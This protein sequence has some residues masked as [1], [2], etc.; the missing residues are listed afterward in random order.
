MPA[1]GCSVILGVMSVSAR[2][3]VNLFAPLPPHAVVDGSREPTVS[4]VIPVVGDTEGLARLVRNLRS[5][6]APPDEIVIVDGGSSAGCR[7]IARRFRCVYVGTRIGRGHQLHAGAL[8]ASGD[9]LWFLHVDTEPPPDGVMLI[10]QRHLAGHMGGFFTFRF[11]GS[12]TWYKRALSRLINLRTRFGV[13]SG[14][15]GLFVDRVAYD[16]AGGFAD[17]PV[18]E[19]VPLVRALRRRGSF[20]RVGPSIGVSPRPWERDGWMWHSV[21]NRMLAIAYVAGVPPRRLVRRYQPLGPTEFPSVE[22]HPI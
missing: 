8:R 6:P 13:P 5:L 20:R 14:H 16:A 1:A 22:D 12:T 17:T 11:T 18:F 19:E 7:S 2:T 15:Q 10:R 3:V 4:V 21:R 9:V